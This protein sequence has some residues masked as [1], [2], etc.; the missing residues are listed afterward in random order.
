MP[1]ED[2]LQ[3]LNPMILELFARSPARLGYASFDLDGTEV[4]KMWCGACEGGEETGSGFGV[5]F[6]EVVKGKRS[7]GCWPGWGDVGG[8]EG[9]VLWFCY[10][11]YEE[12]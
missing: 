11:G 8:K 5:P 6:S 3:S 1:Q 2:P 10:A 12:R 9:W 7:E 4:G